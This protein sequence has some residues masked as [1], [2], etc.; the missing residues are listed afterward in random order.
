MLTSAHCPLT[1]CVQAHNT[2]KHCVPSLRGKAVH[3]VAVTGSMT[4]PHTAQRAYHALPFCFL[5]Q[6]S[7]YSMTNSTC[8]TCDLALHTVL[9]LAVLTSSVTRVVYPF[10]QLE[11]LS[12]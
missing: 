7:K 6:H 10:L 5:S 8:Y 3:N 9:F 12:V 1:V 2:F 4:N 11:P